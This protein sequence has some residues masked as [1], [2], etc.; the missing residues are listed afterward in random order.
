MF[1]KDPNFGELG[2]LFANS[3]PSSRTCSPKYFFTKYYKRKGFFGAHFD[4]CRHVGQSVNVYGTKESR[5]KWKECLNSWKPAEGGRRGGARLAFKWRG[6]AS[7]DI[8]IDVT[9]NS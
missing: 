4:I 6:A 2:K 3:S 5:I 9:G 8:R 7:D 1:T